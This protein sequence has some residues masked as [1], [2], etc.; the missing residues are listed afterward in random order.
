MLDVVAE[1]S[2]GPDGIQGFMVKLSTSHFELNVFLTDDELHRLSSVPDFDWAA[3][4]TLQV[5]RCGGARAHWGIREGRCDLLVGED[6]ET[7]DFGVNLPGDVWRTVL[8]AVA[9]EQLEVLRERYAWET[10]AL[11]V[12]FSFEVRRTLVEKDVGG[13]VPAEWRSF[14]VFGSY[15]VARGGGARPLVCLSGAARIVALDVEMESDE[16]RELAGSAEAFV[17][18]L[19]VV[20][21]C[22]RGEASLASARER[23][24]AMHSSR[25]SAFWLGLLESLFPGMV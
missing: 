12:A 19:G 8:Q 20:D 2:E 1:L 21:A 22:V 24:D 13:E 9:R 25:I 5:G 15:D 3:G 4:R 11:H 18:T 16:V 10:P 14:E 23:L 7:W 17:A 6:D